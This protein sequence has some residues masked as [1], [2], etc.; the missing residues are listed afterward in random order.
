MNASFERKLLSENCTLRDA[1]ERLNEG[2]GGALILVDDSGVMT[3]ILTDGDLRR[4]MLGGGGLDD[5]VATH[6]NQD[7]SYA[8]D[9]TQRDELLKAMDNRIRHLP[10]VDRDGRPIDMVSWSDIWQLPISAPSLGGNE[11]KYVSECISTMWISSQGRYVREFEAA[12]GRFVGSNFSISTTSCTTALQ[13]A[14]T[15]LDIGAGDEVIVPACTFGASANAVIQAGAKPIFADIDAHTKTISPDA[16]EAVVS[17]RTR[18]IMPVHLY[19]HPCDMDAIMKIANLHDLYVIEDCAE[20]LGSRYKGQMT[21]TFGDAACFSFFANKVITTGEGGMVLVKDEKLYNRM[22]LLRDHGMSKDRRY[23]HLEAGFNF[24]M[25]NMQAAVGLAQMERIHDFLARR[26]SIVEVYAEM[27]K[28]DDGIALPPQAPWA[29]NIHWLY[30]I[31]FLRHDRNEIMA[32][33]KN[34]G[35]DTRPIFPA[36]HVQPAFGNQPLGTHPVAEMYA[37]RGL[38]LPNSAAMTTDDAQQVAERILKAML[39]SDDRKRAI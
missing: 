9:G 38:C 17:E 34:M 1:N 31:E 26:L 13:L 6:M 12:V 30:C 11:L 33:M 7:F 19:G 37:E 4:A 39:Q 21:G 29:H 5:C 15:A 32:L 22:C 35:V 36:L 14:V 24:R 28:D 2:V 23:W 20:S 25:T 8:A 16:I 10:I 3:G 18:A 27:L